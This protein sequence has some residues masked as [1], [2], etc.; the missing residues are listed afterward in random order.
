MNT[1]LVRNPLIEHRLLV[2]L[3]IFYTISS[4]TSAILVARLMQIGPLL[5]PGGIFIFPFSYAIID[6][7][8]E[9]YGYQLAS[10]LILSL[11]IGSI[12]YAMYVF[13]ILH[14]PYPAW[15]QHN[16]NYQQVL[17]SSMRLVF[18]GVIANYLASK[19]NAFVLVKLK[20]L[21][22]G[23]SF[24]IR[25]IIASSIGE[26]LLTTLVY[27]GVMFGTASIS[28]IILLGISGYFVKVMLA[29]LLAFPSQLVV[30]YAKRTGSFSN[31]EPN[32]KQTVC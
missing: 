2:I 4:L 22:K 17:S 7:V 1:T 21:L 12:F 32:L 23:K 20:L 31:M 6:I 29:I 14:V 13:F 28:N 25:S 10:K 15:W 18:W 5:L 19:L 27:V 26:L 8:A 3:C 24:P 16:D 11:S 30:A 9:L